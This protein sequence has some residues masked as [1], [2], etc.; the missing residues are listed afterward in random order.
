MQQTMLY[1]TNVSLRDD[2]FI[3]STFLTGTTLPG[4]NK[5]FLT[6]KTNLSKECFTCYYASFDKGNAKYK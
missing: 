6:S 4:K 2:F 3:S 1:P 5:T